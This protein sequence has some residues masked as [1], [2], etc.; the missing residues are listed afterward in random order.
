MKNDLFEPKDLRIILKEFLAGASYF[1]LSLLVL[2]AILFFLLLLAVTVS[3]WYL[4]LG[5]II[6]VAVM[7]NLGFGNK[8]WRS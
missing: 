1:F 2:F 3:G 6:A 8:K 7:I 4:F 5:I